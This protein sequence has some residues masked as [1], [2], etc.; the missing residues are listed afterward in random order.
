MKKIVAAFALALLA[1]CATATSVPDPNGIPFAAY[2]GEVKVYDKM[3]PNAQRVGVV[4]SQG[5]LVHNTAELTDALK[6]KAAEMGANGI[7]I[8]KGR[9]IQGA[10]A[11]FNARP[12]VEM[13]AVAFRVY[14]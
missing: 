3:P 14:N 12:M 8:T 5:G 13:S 9:E 4:I 11:F 2:S 1:G 6:K 10:E 7:M